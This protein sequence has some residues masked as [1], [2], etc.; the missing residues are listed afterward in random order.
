MPACTV[1]EVARPVS[2]DHPDWLDH[3]RLVHLG[4]AE[5]IGSNEWDTDPAEDHRS[6]AANT[7]LHVRRW[8]AR[9]G[10]AALGHARLALQLRDSDAAAELNVFVHPDHRGQGIGRQLAE[11]GLAAARAAGARLVH[12]YVSTPVI[13]E[14]SAVTLLRS[15]TGHGV[16]PADHPGVRLARGLGMT[17]GQIERVSRYELTGSTEL[18]ERAFADA[19]AYAGAD[20]R[21]H[22]W[23]GGV[24][25]DRLEAMAGLVSRMSIDIPHGGLDIVAERWDA[26][27]I[28]DAYAEYAVT[29]RVFLAVAEHLPTGE[30]VAYNELASPE[31]SPANA[32]EQWDTL[33]AGPHRGHRLG[34]LVKAAN[35]LRLRVEAPE[36][37]YVMTWNA[38]ENT[39]MLRVNE[40][41]GFTG[42]LAEAIFELSL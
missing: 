26:E 40:E 9:S 29:H 4:N 35:L 18:L 1:A 33:V 16:V 8:L 24:P 30:L 22:L 10:D 28:R 7:N 19:E 15:P 41:I 23:E 3:R 39:P 42:F 5:T 11:A 27:R 14:P 2:P 32:V 6:E 12:S 13:T 17:L 38:A 36:A 31:A 25:E 20:Y 37:P 34:K 21:V